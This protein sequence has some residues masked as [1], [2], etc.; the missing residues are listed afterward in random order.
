MRVPVAIAIGMCLREAGRALLHPISLS[1]SLQIVERSFEGAL[2]RV[3]R[4]ALERLAD[5]SGHLLETL[6][7]YFLEPSQ[8]VPCVTIA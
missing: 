8:S 6:P 3:H 4:L 1:G 7:R 2:H 5:G